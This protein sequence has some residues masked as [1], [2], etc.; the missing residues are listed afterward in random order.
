MMKKRRCGIIAVIFTVLQFNFVTLMA[1]NPQEVRLRVGDRLQLRVEDRQELDR[2]M[3]IDENGEVFI[4]VVGGIRIEGMLLSGARS[5]IL[6]KL[7]EV[8]PSVTG[9]EVSLYGEEARRTIYV[10][11]EVVQP[12]RYEF[13]EPPNV[14]EAIREAGGATPRAALDAVRIIRGD[15]EDRKGEVIDLES[16]IDSGDFASLPVLNLGDTVFI[17]ERDSG[18][19]TERGINVIGAVETPGSYNLPQSKRLE[20]AILAAGGPSDNA[21]LSAVKIIRKMPEGNVLTFE[22]DFEKYLDKGRLEGNP[23]IHPGDTVNIPRQGNILKAIFTNPGYVVGIVTA[24]L[25]ITAIMVR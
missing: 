20:D 12:G 3:T 18:Y 19:G 2:R 10:Q 1:L 23:M 5:I 11:G 7:R 6:E 24:A 13:M 17:P 25:T 16:I 15:G 4:P 9:I 14:W 8:Y 22:I 21:D